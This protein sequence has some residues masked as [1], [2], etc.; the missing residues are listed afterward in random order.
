[1]LE[2]IVEGSV[3][4]SVEEVVLKML[5][6][7]RTVPLPSIQSDPSST[8]SIRLTMQNGCFQL[9]SQRLQIDLQRDV[10]PDTAFF[11]YLRCGGVWRLRPHAGAV[12]LYPIFG[13]FARK[14]L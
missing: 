4:K 13:P 5:S 2:D 12:P 8:L 10:S 11:I 6:P 1:M 7:T 9:V 3:E 14:G